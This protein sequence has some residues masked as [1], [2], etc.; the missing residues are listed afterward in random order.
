MKV[1][2]ACGT[3]DELA[4]FTAGATPY[5]DLSRLHMSENDASFEL[6]VRWIHAQFFER[7]ETAAALDVE[8][9][10]VEHCDTTVQRSSPTQSPMRRLELQR[11]WGNTKW[12]TSPS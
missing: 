7:A 12:G 11:S 3:D 10:H 4:S 8:S 2:S 5:A 1:R 9:D 6:I